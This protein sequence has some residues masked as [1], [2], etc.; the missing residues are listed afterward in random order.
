MVGENEDFR[1]Y[2]LDEL[3]GGSRTKIEH[4]VEAIMESEVCSRTAGEEFLSYMRSNWDGIQ[5]WYDINHQ[6]GPSCAEGLVSHVLSSRLS[7]RPL[8]WLDEG[9][10]TISR[11]R[12][13]VLNGGT[14][15]PE[16][17]HRKRKPAIRP[18]K[19]LKQHLNFDVYNESRILHTDHRSSPEYRLFKAIA[20]GG[21]A[22]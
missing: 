5:I 16:N 15:G 4:L 9:L 2:I 21:L 1:Q 22:V 14:I 17:L 7:S 11:L 19:R 20:R 18:T 8:G 3:D 13:H 12:V 6:A 10:K